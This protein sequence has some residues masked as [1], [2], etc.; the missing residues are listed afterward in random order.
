M[1]EPATVAD[2]V[3]RQGAAN[4]PALFEELNSRSGSGGQAAYGAQIIALLNQTAPIEANAIRHYLKRAGHSFIF[5]AIDTDWLDTRENNRVVRRTA[6]MPGLPWPRNGITAPFIRNRIYDDL[7]Q[8]R[9]SDLSFLVMRRDQVLIDARCVIYDNEINNSGP[10]V[11]LIY[12]TDEPSQRQSAIRTVLRH[13]RLL[14]R[15]YCVPRVRL[16]VDDLTATAAAG[17]SVGFA[18]LRNF[19]NIH[20]DLTRN[21]TE[22]W[23]H[24]RKSYRPLITRYGHRQPTVSWGFGE[25]RGFFADKF[26]YGP[27]MDYQEYMMATKAGVLLTW[28]T[29]NGRIG[30]AIGLTDVAT[31]PDYRTCYFNIGGFDKTEPGHYALYSALLYL[32]RQS[33]QRFYLGIC[34]TDQDRSTKIGSINFFKSGFSATIDHYRIGLTSMSMV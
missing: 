26:C 34:S 32:K 8:E 22:I 5:N 31:G 24:L 18:G 16:L 33:C 3:R 14:R 1:T 6:T 11:T 19:V 23:S 20:V 10:P 29:E 17:L 9:E 2:L 7:A 13:L 27:S 12:G 28:H 15:V 21:D 30:A 25:A 4:T